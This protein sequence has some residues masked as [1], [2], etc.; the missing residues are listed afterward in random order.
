MSEQKI[1]SLTREQV[2]A[3]DALFPE[4]CASLEWTDR[5][6]W[7]KSGQRS[8]VRFLKRQLEIQDENILNT[9]QEVRLNVHE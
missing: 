8:V 6:V 4:Q 9:P 5:E 2:D 1:P 7:F 3:L